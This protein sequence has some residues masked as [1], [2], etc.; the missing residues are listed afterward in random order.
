MGMF[1]LIKDIDDYYTFASSFRHQH[2]IDPLS[3]I[4]GLNPA[5]YPC[6]INSVEIFTSHVHQ[7]RD[8]ANDNRYCTSVINEIYYKSQA[9]KLVYPL[10]R[11][12]I[13]QRSMK[14]N[15]M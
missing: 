9:K 13:R 12:L 4:R 5:K 3:H 14:I 8:R 2:N 10:K 11:Q 1:K 7:N 6:L 15:N